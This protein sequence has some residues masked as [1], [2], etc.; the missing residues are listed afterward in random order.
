M[1]LIMDELWTTLTTDAKL[2]DLKMNSKIRIKQRLGLHN[3]YSNP[4][5]M[6][7]CG[8]ELSKEF[9]SFL[10]HSKLLA[11]YK[12]RFSALW[13]KTCQDRD[14]NAQHHCHFCFL[15]VILKQFRDCCLLFSFP[16]NRK[17][18]VFIQKEAWLVRCRP[19]CP[20]DW[21]TL[22]CFHSFVVSGTGRMTGGWGCSGHGM[23]GCRG[24]GRF[25]L[26]TCLASCLRRSCSSLQW[27]CTRSHWALLA[28]P[29]A[30]HTSL[31]SRRS[32]QLQWSRWL[33][34]KSRNSVCGTETVKWV[35]SFST[36]P[37]SCG[38]SSRSPSW[39]DE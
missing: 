19:A 17:R 2:G 6:Q 22:E 31:S 7:R 27:V 32:L 25:L 4:S 13:A 10:A 14:S 18:L 16:R 5:L 36:W 11:W 39:G 26:R 35:W 8:D 23:R 21:R 37:R 33:P 29:C 3:P 34:Q 28:S 9:A 1:R 24:P 30:F 20:R 38:T 12:I 15:H